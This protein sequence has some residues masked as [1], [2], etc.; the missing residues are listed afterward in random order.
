MKIYT[1]KG[2]TGKTSLLGGTRV[3]KY[4]LR[5]EAYGTVDELNSFLG[6]LHDQPLLQPAYGAL[7]QQIQSHLFTIGSILANDPEKS[8]FKLP[9]ITEAAVKQLEDSMD[10]MEAQLPALKTFIL[11]GGHPANST[12]HMARSICRRAERRVVE[13]HD[14]SPLDPVISAYLNRLSDWCFMLAR[15][16]SQLAGTE[17][18]PWKG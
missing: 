6:L 10:E 5:I 8:K 11:P 15:M 13:L 3:P 7:I 4:D 2:D 9:S 18:V 16:A 12:A 1:K 14:H 17:E